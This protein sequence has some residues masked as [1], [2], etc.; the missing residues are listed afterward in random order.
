MSFSKFDNISK[1]TREEL[2]GYIDFLMWQYRL[3]D[4]FWFLTA[5]ETFNL[6]VASKLNEDVWSKIS[7]YMA[8]DIKRRFKISGKGVEAVLDALSYNPWAFITKYSVEKGEDK[9][10]ISVPSCT[11]QVARRKRGKSEFLCRNMHLKVF[12]NFAKEIDDKVK[13]KCLFA[14]PDPHPK[15]LW[16]K[17][18]F[19]CLVTGRKT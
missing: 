2:I 1:A 11:P 6:E 9:A 7:T 4:A 17:W 15:D 19:I 12:T 10:V 18:E 8:R 3:V 16:C 5:E 14:P 13:V